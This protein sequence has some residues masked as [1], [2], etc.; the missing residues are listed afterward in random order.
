MGQYLTINGYKKPSFISK[1][2]SYKLQLNPTEI[3]IGVGNV[4]NT[5][6]DTDTDAIGS[7]IG[8]KAPIFRQRTL[9][10]SFTIDNTGAVPNKPDGM[11]FLGLGNLVDS[12]K[13]FEKVAIDEVATEHRPPFV[14]IS[15]GSNFSFSGIVSSYKYNYTFFNSSGTPL[16]AV[17]TLQIKDF[18]QNDTSLFQSPDITKMPVIKDGDTI[19]KF[20]EEYYDDKKYY[21]KLA[22]FNNLNSV[23]SLKNGSQLEIPPIK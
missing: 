23:R 7:V 4:E 3:S 13:S 15:W 18:D 12:M 14:R 2:G 22:E 11:G 21:I 8:S 19:V 17:V 9:D 6:E 16:R 10:L 1:I 5:D 20:C